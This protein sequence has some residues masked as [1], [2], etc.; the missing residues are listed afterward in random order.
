M[1]SYLKLQTPVP[2]KPLNLH[3]L[4]VSPKKTLKLAMGDFQSLGINQK[5]Y[6]QRN[7]ERTQLIGAAIN[8]LEFDGLLA[9]SARYKCYNLMLFENNYSLEAKLEV[10]STELVTPPDWQKF[11]SVGS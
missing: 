7:Y 3:T 1:A 4:A 10:K 6:G 11:G 9:P 5:L 2:N 8:F